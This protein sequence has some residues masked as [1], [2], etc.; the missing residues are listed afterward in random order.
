MIQA[1]INIFRVAELRN[2]VL[3]TL[4]MLVIYR[5]GFWIPL[6]GVDQSQ[7][8]KA[9]EKASENATGFG[10][11]AQFAS[12]FSGG[13]LQQ[14]TIFGLG[15]MPYITAGIIFQLLQSVVPSLADL[16]KEG[17]SGQQ[18]IAEW[19]RYAAVAL[20][21]FQGW[22]WLSYLRQTNLVQPQFDSGANLVVFYV[23]GFSAL[24]AGSLFLM[25]LGEQIDKYGIGNGVSIILTAGILARMPH[26]VG[27]VVDNFDPRQ[28][29]D[30]E[31]KIG[32]VGVLLLA[33][34]FILVTAGAIVITVAQ[35]RIP[36]Q[37][38]KHTTGRKMYG[39]QK[40]YLPLRLN[41]AG[42]MPIIF[43]SSL[44]VFPSAIFGWLST[45]AQAEGS[46]GI[47]AWISNF[48]SENFQH[49]AYPYVVTEIALIY[50]F[51]YFWTTVQFSPEEMSKQLRDHGSMVPGIRPGPW[52]SE[53]LERTM[54]R[55]TYVGAGFLAVIAIIPTLVTQQLGIPFNVSQFLGGTGLLIVVSVGL[56]LVQRIEA[57]L[58]M[59][60]YSGF[61][62]K[63]SDSKGPRI[64]SSRA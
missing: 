53:Y 20:C 16:K 23:A 14:S 35:R 27:W 42:V 28:S 1:F 11:I 4:G 49:G 37:Q 10:R 19:T 33:G 46:T 12:I 45:R 15:I 59:R 64:R 36:I 7:L 55:I 40:T 13:S 44:M 34:G 32:L 54:E 47:G 9:A 18:K 51:S 8:A 56:D 21:V 17:A 31:G 25:W 52:T 39:G 29:S 26:A 2:R 57:N 60:N 24:T 61:L 63:G 62:S 5:I 38:A 30:A 48:L 22:M 50:F 58:V 6:V 3:F 43:A 41:H